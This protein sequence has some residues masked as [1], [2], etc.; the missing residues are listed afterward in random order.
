VFSLSANADGT[1]IKGFAITST[2][3]NVT[4]AANGVIG[5][6]L[7]GPDNITIQN[8]YFY[9]LYNVAI[10]STGASPRATG[11]LIDSNLIA[12]AKG[13][14]D[15]NGTYYAEGFA[16]ANP[17]YID[18]LIFSNNRI[19]GYGRGVQ[20]EENSNA[21]VQTNYISDIFYHGIQAAN[22]Q[23]NTLIEGNTVDRAQM[24]AYNDYFYG[25]YCTGGIRL[26]TNDTSS[27]FIVRNNLVSNTGATQ[28]SGIADD[29]RDL[30]PAIALNGSNSAAV[31]SITNNSLANGS[32]RSGSTNPGLGIVWTANQIT[33]AAVSSGIATVKT[34]GSNS[35]ATNDVVTISGLGAPFDGTWTITKSG[36]QTVTFAVSGAA[37]VARGAATGG[38]YNAA[39]EATA[40]LA[41]AGATIVRTSGST[42]VGAI[43][44]ANNFWGSASGP[45]TTGSTVNA[46]GASIASSPYIASYTPDPNKDG[47]GFWPI[48]MTQTI[49]FTQP[50]AMTMTTADQALAATSSA[51]GSYPVSLASTTTSVCTIVNGAVHAVSAGTCSITA[52]QA[53]D[54][55]YLAASNVSKSFEITKNAQ[56]ITF[57]QPIAM[58]MTTADQALVATSSAGISYPVSFTSTTTSVCT[59]VNRAVHVVSAGTC[60]IT[61]SQA[62]DGTYSPA[63][64]VVETLTISKLTQTITFT[65][66]TEM[67]V[68]SDPQTLVA[69]SS[70]G[71]LYP[72]TFASTTSSIC[73]VVNGAIEAVAAGTCS[74]TAS[75]AGDEIYAAAVSATKSIA[76]ANRKFAQTI[77]FTQ[78]AA[79][80]K[81][82][83]PQTL[84]AT[85]SADGS[86]PVTFTTTSPACSISGT[87]LTVV[88]AGTCS[89]TASQAG[90]GTYLAASNVGRAIS[91]TKLANTITFTSPVA[92][93][94]TSDPQTLV[95]T[96]SADGSYPVTF[97]TTSPACSISGTTLTV[98]SAGTC[99]ITASQAGDGTYLAAANVSKSF[100]ITKSAQTINF[101]QPAAMTTTSNPQPLVATSSAG[102]SYLVAF[103]STTSTICTVV[104]GAIQVVKTGTCSITASRSGDGTYL[105][106]I[107]VVRS[108]AI[109]KLA[110]TLDFTQPTA[111]TMASDPQP[112]FAT[113]STGSSVT[114]TSATSSVCT[115]VNDA[116]RVVK[117]GTCSITASQAGN[118]TNSVASNVIKSITI[119]KIAQTITFT[120]PT[121]MT[122]RSTPQ[123]L[124][125]TSSA[126]GS[127]PVTFVST[128]SSVCT[129]VNGAIRVIRAGTC[130][131]TA[132][133]AGDGTYSTASKVSRSIVVTNN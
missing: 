133:R 93:T 2:N 19:F 116:I 39:S 126:G 59:I 89:I 52:S 100:V 127:Y 120:Q 67:T 105:P 78:P 109:T 35:L 90:D 75:Q 130:S 72:V 30:C 34:F 38:F 46:G 48:N 40:I 37:D 114:F 86:Y 80:T 121:A 111:M 64:N 54:G 44:A 106:A 24:S 32:N 56:T 62:G 50:I 98:V 41:S 87:T 113:T 81:T 115:V 20:L 29:Y 21:K 97:T 12:N 23:T 65:Q 17:W 42:Q 79:M 6:N 96:S 110:N 74:I 91:I 51:G 7:L 60:S 102:S 63:T 11:Y 104:N 83:S 57:T 107:N 45:S 103:A 94:M 70:A 27:G 9:D 61:A 73:T 16:G 85:S 22:G 123:A 69:T 55:T 132:S 128:T 71:G 88:S 28:R 118:A 131:I 95:A 108:I 4:P 10:Y 66:P 26:W 25:G 117:A 84:V 92:M 101:T 77:T 43:S 5:I 122:R 8:N 82:S 33:H 124:D 53:G 125:A 119:T 47:P 112:L 3:G 15:S 129:V 68:T 1:V 31:S 14:F 36:T 13:P 58:T 99:S 49:T 76:V 18:N